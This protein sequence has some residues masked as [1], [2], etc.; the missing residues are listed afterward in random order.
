MN[1][2]SV[3]PMPAWMESAWL[4]RYLEKGL[5]PAEVEWFEAYVLDKPALL[6]AIELDA[7][8][9]DGLAAQPRAAFG[10]IDSGPPARAAARGP[11]LAAMLVL[12]VLGGWLGTRALGPPPENGRVVASPPRIIFD[13]LRGE[14]EPA[15]VERT[16]RESGAVIVD[17]AVPANAENV[18]LTL[19]PTGTLALTPGPEGFATVILGS[20][21]VRPGTTAELTYV[22]GGSRVSRTLA[23]PAL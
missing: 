18:R 14:G 17:I 11:A 19:A 8:L 3:T 9:R 10:R 16:G 20:A 7:N 22:L 4:A 13:T 6:E 2:P 5:E 15:R 1:V 23:W 12:G 21:L